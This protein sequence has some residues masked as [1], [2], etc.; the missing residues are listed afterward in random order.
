[1]STW[2]YEED[3]AAAFPA[4]RRAGALFVEPVFTAAGVVFLLMIPP[5]LAAML[6]DDR[7]HLGLDIWLKP[8]KFQ[9]ALAIFAFTMAVYARWL[10]A[11]TVGRRWH[12]IYVASV[13]AAMGAEIVWISGAAALGT[14]SHF[15]ATPVG[16][17]FYAAAGVLAVWFT[18]ATLVYGVLIARNR[19]PG[20]DPAL[21]WGL[22]LGLVLTFVLSVAFAGYMSNSG[23]HFVG[24]A[25]SDAGGLWPMGWSRVV[26]DLRVAHFFGTHAM[27]AVPLAGFVAGLVLARR[28]AV[29]ATWGFAALWAA[30]CVAVFAQA[31]A[32]APFLPGEGGSGSPRNRRPGP[33]PRT[34]R[35][36]L[37][38]EPGAGRRQGQA[39]FAGASHP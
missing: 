21:R 34:H 3:Y 28:P 2:G 26:G 38:P 6:A 20:F 32:G 4:E 25:T 5:T 22:A 7:L 30:F 15:N 14:T 37:M 33:V 10:P 23:S 39:G 8:L 16:M 27:H 31:L 18:G 11:G 36:V 12:R 17:A 24:A 9:V 13:V 1:M 19:R 35:R 29:W